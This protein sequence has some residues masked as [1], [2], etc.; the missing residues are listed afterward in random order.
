MS[1]LCRTTILLLLLLVAIFPASAQNPAKPDV[2]AEIPG[3][4]PGTG[5]LY[6]TVTDRSTGE[7][8]AGANVVIDGTRLGAATDLEGRYEILEIA[9]GLY[10]VLA[11]YIGYSR[12]V[13]TD[14]AISP[15]RP[16]RLDFRLEQT[17]IQLEEVVV[18]AP[19]FQ[20][21]SDTQI[22]TVTVS[23]E[24]IRRLPGGFEDVL[25]AVSIL[26]GV[27][28]P[29]AGRNDLI[30]RGGAP[31]ENLYL[32][33][34][35][36]I[37]NINHFG[38]QGSSGGPQSFVNLDYVD[39]TQFNAGGFGVRY[40]DRLSSVLRID[41]REGRDDRLGGKATV[42]A[43]QFG[44]DLE[45]PLPG[46]GERG[47][48][49]LSARRSYLD[50]LFKALGVS[51]IPQYWDF[52][53]KASRTLGPRDFL[54]FTGVGAID[55]V[56]L[57]NNNEDQRYDNSTVLAPTQNTAAGGLTWKHLFGRGFST[58]TLA[59]V[60]QD[61]NAVQ[62]DSLLVPIF[63]NTSIEREWSL[64][65]DVVWKA[66]DHTELAFGL[67]QKIGFYSAGQFARFETSFGD[68]LTLDQ[69]FSL[70]TGK[71]AAYL[72]ASQTLGKL[73][74][75]IGG[76]LDA[77][78]AIDRGTAF[79]PRTSATFALTPV[80]NLNASL[81]RYFQSPSVIW[82]LSNP[83]NRDL[84]LIGADQAVVGVDH[85]LR[86][87][88]RIGVEAYTKSYFDYPA[89]VDRPW[90]VMANTGAGFGG[91]QDNFSSYGYD[92]LVS[93]GGGRARGFEIFGQKKAGENPHYA[94]VSLSYNE[95]RF[96]GLDGIERPGSFDQRWI[97]NLGGGFIFNNNLETSFR[98]RLATGM[99]Y[100]PFRQDGS[101]D[102][103]KYNTE[104]TPVNHSL[105]IRVD[106]RWYFDNWTLI[107]YLDVQNV[108]DNPFQG[109]PRWDER[110]RQAVQDES[111]GI[112]PS[113]GVSVEF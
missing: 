16:V 78:D 94:L 76:R 84:S 34:N 64:R 24:E 26:P 11:T 83:A 104:R 6:G 110:T 21:D 92:H 85:L 17:A 73:K 98:F 79:S 30:V 47:S 45:G 51:F 33:D 1:V 97:F 67:Q 59:H 2:A 14:I 111:I 61:F 75:T 103:E 72:Q 4:V 40:G 42:S 15:A 20:K 39:R 38:T 60:Y 113:I 29:M 77:F 5:R 63:R 35:I 10:P 100:T 74:L 31:S 81:G 90:L 102:P 46:D 107:S 7:P 12:Q 62:K 3:N 32:L 37:P 22:S 69:R 101:Q 36:E 70:S 65:G 13:R 56:T 52:L 88:V 28:Q 55:F 82:L 112:L 66:F 95:T 87:D 49:L 43:S 93:Q 44:L 106:R 18:R 105:D 109:A 25:R 8:I 58:L 48:F 57:A 108:Y 50:F 54:K 53:G 99:P 68:S 41:L 96:T 89:S 71:S 91:S 9:P 27:A 23:N 19:L 86:Y 80:T